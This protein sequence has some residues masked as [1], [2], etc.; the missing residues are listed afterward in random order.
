MKK[1]SNKAQ[2]KISFGMIF[3]IILIIVFITFA[4][5]GIRRF[6]IIHDSFKAGNLIQDL[7][8]DIDKMRKSTQGSQ[9]V[10]YTAPKE[11]EAFCFQE[12]KEISE[13]NNAYFM[14]PVIGGGILEYINWRETGGRLGSNPKCFLIEN[15][16]LT[17]LLEKDYG[18]S[19]VTIK[20]YTDFESEE[21]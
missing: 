18:E 5:F 3:S 14:P 13:D 20:E 6:F 16:K 19:L 15:S 12:Q 11:A 9:K 1:R 10:S 8:E 2:M 17:L 21:L 4:F 7:Q